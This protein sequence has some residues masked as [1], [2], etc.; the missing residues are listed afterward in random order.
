MN[1]KIIIPF[2]LVAVAVI[3]IFIAPVFNFEVSDSQCKTGGCSGQICSASPLDYGA[4]TTCDWRPE[5]GCNK[6]CKVRNFQCSF[7]Q[8][9]KQ[10]CMNCIQECG[11]QFDFRTGDGS[12]YQEFEECT[13]SCYER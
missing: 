3:I 4:V 11:N 10:S 1:K 7:D 8:E 9:F 12:I 13:I 6:D 5:Y 2:I